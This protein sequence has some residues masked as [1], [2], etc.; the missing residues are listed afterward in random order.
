VIVENRKLFGQVLRESRKAAGLTLRGL[1]ERAGVQFSNISAIESGRIIAG[2]KQATK[3]V[4]G[5][6]LRGQQKEDL[7]LAASLSSRRSNPD[8]RGASLLTPFY[9]SI[10]WLLQQLGLKQLEGNPTVNSCQFPELPEG[11]PPLPVFFEHPS[12]NS[13]FTKSR[14]LKPAAAEYMKKNP[15][16]HFIALV[17]RENN[18][19]TLIECTS[20]VFA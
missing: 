17:V 12:L 7:L 15:S 1:A 2:A 5:L 16:K 10:P 13:G 4:E 9:R 20:T 14:I 6:G 11:H 18:S 3:L 8:L 19:Q